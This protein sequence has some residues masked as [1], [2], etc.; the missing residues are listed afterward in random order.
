MKFLSCLLY[1]KGT[2]KPSPISR[3]FIHAQAYFFV[4]HL[5]AVLPVGCARRP[6]APSAPVSFAESHPLGLQVEY[7][8]YARLFFA[9]LS[10]SA[11]TGATPLDTSLP[12]LEVKALPRVSASHSNGSL[13]LSLSEQALSCTVVRWPVGSPEQR[14]QVPLQNG[15][16]ALRGDGR[17]YLYTLYVNYADGHAVYAFVEIS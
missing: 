17:Y 15:R 14:E 6:A 1:N 13:A 5:T 16:V 12:Q 11:P 7:Q 9:A 4:S 3:S 8:G 10:A 2:S